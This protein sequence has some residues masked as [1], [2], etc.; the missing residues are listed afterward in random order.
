MK[1]K[2]NIRFRIILGDIKRNIRL[3]SKE[4]RIIR[5]E[6]GRNKKELDQHLHLVHQKGRHIKYLKGEE[7]S[8]RT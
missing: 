5:N 1:M 7:E 8:E 3:Q 4:M 2:D 6:I